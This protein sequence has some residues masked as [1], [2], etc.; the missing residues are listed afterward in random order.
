MD[1]LDGPKSGLHGFRT[2]FDFVKA[3]ISLGITIS[4]LLW[5]V[6]TYALDGRYAP[7]E[8]SVAVAQNAKT[9]SDVKRTVDEI[10]ASL[11]QSQIFETKIKACQASS[12]EA[13]QFFAQRIQELNNQYMSV[14]GDRTTLP[15][16]NDLL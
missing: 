11:L 10:Q 5:A 14:T 9:A 4:A 12:P 16:C 13:K 1:A 3:T 2:W 6:L 8:I 7:A 15:D